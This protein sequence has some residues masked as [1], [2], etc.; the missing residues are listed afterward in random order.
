MS[1]PSAKPVEGAL[2]SSIALRLLSAFP[3]LMAAQAGPAEQPETM[4]AGKIFRDC[5]DCPQMVVIPAGTFRMGAPES[6]QGSSPLEQPV[7]EVAV[8]AF[9][10]GRFD[11]TRGEW[12]AFVRATDRAT[13][14]GC[15]YTGRPVDFIDPNGSW[16][17]LGFSQTDRHPVV[18][19]TWN[20]AGDYAA[21]LSKRTGKHYRLLSE[22]EWEYAA[23]AGGSS[24]Y[25]WGDRL[26]H[27]HANYGP[28]TGYGKGVAKGKDRWV[29]TSPVGAF[30]AN[31]FGLFDMSGNVLQYVED[32]LS[33]SY[34]NTPADGSA[35]TKSVPLA[36]SGDFSDLNGASSC[37]FRIARGGDWADPPGQ[38]RP[39]FRNFAPPPPLPLASFASGG[40]GF[41]VARDLSH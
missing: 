41:R 35:Y 9:A 40:V 22:A 18:C 20:D 5:P 30:P 36:A 1:L 10:A 14:S 33:L 29:Y 8:R 4:R 13:R 24:I 3:L 32:C 11:V 16:S 28:E 17:S 6:E 15:A 2:K 7:H 12:A 21:W 31:A 23:R 19:I 27:S 25:A 26:D 39:G 34:A 38:V 37:D